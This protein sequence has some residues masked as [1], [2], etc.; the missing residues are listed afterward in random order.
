MF[1]MFQRLYFIAVV[2][3][4]TAS[5]ANALDFPERTNVLG[6]ADV[7]GYL[8]HQVDLGKIDLTEEVSI[9]VRIDFS[10]DPKRSPSMLGWGWRFPLL[11]SRLYLENKKTVRLD[12]INGETY[13]L[14]EGKASG[15]YELPAGGM[16]AERGRRADVFNVTFDDGWSF[17]YSNGV[18]MRFT[19]PEG[20][21]FLLRQ[22]HRRL[23]S[24][25]TDDR[26]RPLFEVRYDRSGKA[27]EQLIFNQDKTVDFSFTDIRW[28]FALNSSSELDLVPSDLRIESDRFLNLASIEF[29]GEEAS[30]S[31]SYSQGEVVTSR[32]KLPSQGELAAPRQTSKKTLPSE[33]SVTRSTAPE[34]V[35]GWDGV[36]GH[37]TRAGDDTYKITP[38]LSAYEY[39]K[40]ERVNVNG[41]VDSWDHDVRSGVKTITDLDGGAQRTYY[42]LSNGPLYG[43]VRKVEELRG[44]NVVSTLTNSFDPQGRLRR[45]ISDGSVRVWDWEDLAEGS[46]SIEYFNGAIRRKSV[47]RGDYLTEREVYLE[48]GD[49]SQYQYG[50]ADGIKWVTHFL[51]GKAVSHKEMHQ[52]GRLSRIKWASGKEQFWTYDDGGQQ[53][54]TIYEDGRRYLINRNIGDLKFTEVTS[55][56]LVSSFVDALTQTRK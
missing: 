30:E 35:Y 51:N 25:I 53:M 47:Y 10:S 27:P 32:V 38:R 13:Y 31:Y 3:S 33:F 22:G 16:V 8:N 24:G 17:D 39:S 40:V 45:S 26:G 52:D 37:L 2:C 34:Y 23:V 50:E 54:L 9:P 41:I 44:G 46:S 12:A 28:K 56:V 49:V 5:V 18:L 14:Y 7:F 48:N 11:E 21:T 20:A 55:N 42:I 4:L 19:L 36:S 15:V 43:K 6:A 1:K 29:G